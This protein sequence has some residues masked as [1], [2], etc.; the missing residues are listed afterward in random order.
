MGKIKNL[1]NHF[2]F[3]SK[4]CSINFFCNRNKQET[5]C[6][7]KALL[8]KK[9][10]TNIGTE[11]INDANYLTPTYALLNAEITTNKN[12]S[13]GK[14]GEFKFCK[15]CFKTIIE[16]PALYKNGKRLNR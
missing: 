15:K 13:K 14:I 1:F 7:Q 10:C 5:T 2:R 4:A 6:K 8:L 11:S 16:S 9:T 3:I 12:W